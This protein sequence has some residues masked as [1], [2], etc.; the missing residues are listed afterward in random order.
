MCWGPLR[1]IMI[2][3]DT[4]FIHLNE[5]LMKMVPNYQKK[6][7]DSFAEAA[8]SLPDVSWQSHS[9]KLMVRKLSKHKTNKEKISSHHVKSAYR[10]AHCC[11]KFWEKH[12]DFFMMM[13]SPA[14]R[15]QLQNEKNSSPHINTKE[16]TTVAWLH[17]FQSGPTPSFFC[18]HTTTLYLLKY[19]IN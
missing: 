6:K 12:K 10:G 18:V 2:V 3:L 19:N 13:V 15:H 7:Q 5:R 11:G 16:L 17:F 4:M 1:G 9:W 8:A 14:C